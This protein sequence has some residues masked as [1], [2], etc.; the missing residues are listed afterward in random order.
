[1]SPIISKAPAVVF[2]EVTGDGFHYIQS[3]KFLD[4]SPSEERKHRPWISQ[5]RIY[6]FTF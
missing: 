4:Y 6:Q 5:L 3:T 1:M 2:G